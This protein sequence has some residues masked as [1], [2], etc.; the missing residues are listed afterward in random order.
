MCRKNAFYLG[1]LDLCLLAISHGKELGVLYWD[2]EKPGQHPVIK[3]GASIME[4]F[5]PDFVI[6]EKP[7]ELNMNSHDTWL[8]AACRSDFVRGS[9]R[10]I[11]HFVPLFTKAQMD[12]VNPS[13]WSECT[14]KCH[15]KAEKAL[16][17]ALRQAEDESDEEISA[18]LTTYTQT[19]V[20]KIE[21]LK[22][23]Q[24][25]ELYCCEVPSDGNCA[26]WSALTLHGGCVMG[27]SIKTDE[28]VT[29]LRMDPGQHFE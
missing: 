23:M 13:L 3:S 21:F 22:T 24:D 16:K 14:S 17:K 18:T 19:L 20:A 5:V 27:R 26:L 29:E 9:F 2:D 11:N 1:I 7:H 15:A 28:H 25:M 10:Q 4:I 12:S 6:W 8:F